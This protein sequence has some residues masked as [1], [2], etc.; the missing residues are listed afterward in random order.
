MDCLVLDI[1]LSTSDFVLLYTN[2]SLFIMME[3]LSHI[4]YKLSLPIPTI[5]MWDIVTSLARLGEE[6]FMINPRVVKTQLDWFDWP[7]SFLSNRCWNFS[8]LP[9]YFLASVEIFSLFQTSQAESRGQQHGWRQDR[10]HSQLD[11]VPLRRQLWHVRHLLCPGKFLKYFLTFYWNIFSRWTWW[12][13]GCR[14]P[15]LQAAPN[16]PHSPSSPASSGTRASAPSTT[17]SLLACFVRPPTQLPGIM[18]IL[19]Y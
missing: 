8:S 7:S 9:K 12:R 18:K 19:K 4:T 10:H 3:M 2:L 6:S 5:I 15:R 13:T 14:W 1:T 11:Q 16:P 17:A